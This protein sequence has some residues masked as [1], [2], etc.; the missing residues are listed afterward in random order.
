MEQVK[1]GKLKESEYVT[2]NLN[3]YK[4][5][6]NEVIIFYVG[7]CTYE[8]AKEIGQMN[9]QGANIVLGGTYIHK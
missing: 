9:R 5:I 7:G 1:S 2:T 3:S 4:G 8:E 6:Y